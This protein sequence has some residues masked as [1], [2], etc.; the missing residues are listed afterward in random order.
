[1]KKGKFMPQACGLNGVCLVDGKPYAAAPFRYSST[2]VSK[3]R[4]EKEHRKQLEAE[5][6]KRE[7]PS[8][9]SARCCSTPAGAGLR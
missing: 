8:A 6:R 9:S 4:W 1:M 7:V 2:V 5:V 3:K